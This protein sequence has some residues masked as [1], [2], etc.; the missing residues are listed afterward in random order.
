M[1]ANCRL[2]ITSEYIRALKGQ[3]K[4]KTLLRLYLRSGD[5]EHFPVCVSVFAP[6]GKPI[7]RICKQFWE[8]RMARGC[9]NPECWQGQ[10]RMRF[11]HKFQQIMITKE[12]FWQVWERHKK[13]KIEH[14]L[15]ETNSE[16]KNNRK[17]KM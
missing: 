3:T 13:T 14:G 5:L 7:E 9:R 4:H 16:V 6:D 2:K 15:W 17:P 8:C 10:M 12:S 1:V 11:E